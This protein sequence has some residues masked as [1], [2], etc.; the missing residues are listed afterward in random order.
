MSPRPYR[1]GRRKD[2]ADDT[3]RR[4][5]AAAAE[6][7][8]A[9]SGEDGFSVDVI[10]KRAGV[11]RMTVY[12]QFGTKRGLLEAVFDS[13]AERGRIARLSEAF[14]KPD[15]MKALDELVAVFGDFWA[16]TRVAHRRLRAAALMDDELA[17]AIAERNERRRQVLALLITRL[18]KKRE[19]TVP[20]A[21]TVNV[22]FTLTSFETFDSLAGAT[23]D[24]A[25]VIPTVQ[26]LARVVL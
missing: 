12:Y 21:E 7:L 18:A 26:R 25:S 8:D 4:V 1:M 6:I 11:A 10:A 16:S 14:R 5:L 22:L 3:R 24:L 20:I 17:T 2:G 15:P 23:H 19:L 9:E 13:L